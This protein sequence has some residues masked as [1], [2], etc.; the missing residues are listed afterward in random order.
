M[1]EP[2]DVV[3][4]YEGLCP[5]ARFL[6]TLGGLREERRCAPWFARVL[7]AA[8]CGTFVRA[9]PD[10]SILCRFTPLGEQVRAYARTLD[11]MEGNA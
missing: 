11:A 1:T 3:A 10:G 8:G 5:D 9:M 2:L 6:L 7:E 4:A